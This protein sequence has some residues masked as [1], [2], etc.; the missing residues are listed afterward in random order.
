MTDIAKAFKAETIRLARKE[1]RLQIE[2]LKK[3]AAQLKSQV[4][5]LRDEIDT[6]KAQVRNLN[7]LTK[8][9][10]AVPGTAPQDASRQRF[11]AKG[12]TTLRERLALSYADMGLLLNASDQSVRKWED[13]KAFPRERSQQAYFDLRGIGKREAAARLE[14]MKQT[15][16]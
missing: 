14:A 3:S 9:L 13:G 1:V 12:L 7:K 4:A 8:N 6:L 10:E 15:Q 2:P 5:A 16:G 11:T